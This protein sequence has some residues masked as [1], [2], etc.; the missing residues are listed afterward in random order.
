MD[1]KNCPNCQQRIS[2]NDIECPYCKYIDDKKISKK[3]HIKQK[4]IIVN[5]CNNCGTKLTKENKCCPKC[6]MDISKKENKSITNKNKEI[7]KYGMIFNALGIIPLPFFVI[8]G[9]IEDIFKIHIDPFISIMCFMLIFPILT[10]IVTIIG[11]IKYPDNDDINVKFWIS[12]LGIPQI[13]ITG[14]IFFFLL[15]AI[16][17][18]D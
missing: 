5:Y 14:A 7:T 13:F 16:T 1:L 4:N 3:K 11:K 9:I 18:L 10:L 17:S 8:L 15:K 12:I 6:G 2:I